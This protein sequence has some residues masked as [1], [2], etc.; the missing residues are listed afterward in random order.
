MRIAHKFWRS[1]KNLIPWIYGIYDSVCEVVLEI[2]CVSVQYLN[3]PPNFKVL[4]LDKKLSLFRSWWLLSL[5]I[6]NLWRFLD[7][8]SKNSKQSRNNKINQITNIF[9]IHKNRRKFFYNPYY[10]VCGRSGVCFCLLIN[11]NLIQFSGI[12]NFKFPY[13]PRQWIF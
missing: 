12:L 5:Q 13:F 11:S 8:S 10:V 3:F 1:Y 2:H 4:K 7:S 9:K 6:H